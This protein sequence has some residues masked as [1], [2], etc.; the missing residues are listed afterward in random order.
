MAVT[1]E[2]IPRGKATGFPATSN[3]VACLG[4]RPSKAHVAYHG[5]L[6]W[7]NGQEVLEKSVLFLLF[8]QWV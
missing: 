8:E 1:Q 3:V 4:D 6:G 7:A 5:K 2:G